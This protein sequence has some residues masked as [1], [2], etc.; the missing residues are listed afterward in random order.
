MKAGKKDLITETEHHSFKQ[1]FSSFG[2][3]ASFARKTAQE[4]ENVAILRFHQLFNQWEVEYTDPA[5]KYWLETGGPE[6]RLMLETEPD[7]RWSQNEEI[8]DIPDP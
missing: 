7:Y 1:Y 6:E 3:T 5:Y 2:E 8:K 4:C